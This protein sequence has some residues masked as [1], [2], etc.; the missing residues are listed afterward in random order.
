MIIY[1]GDVEVGL[2]TGIGWAH[3]DGVQHL[4]YGIGG[5]EIKV[6]V[7]NQAEY[8]AIA[9]D[10]VVAKHL[11]GYNLARTATLVGDILYKI[12][13]TCHTLFLFW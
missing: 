12:C 5:L 3:I 11:L 1:I 4:T 9:I 6:V 7:A 10:A 8:L 2:G 13:I